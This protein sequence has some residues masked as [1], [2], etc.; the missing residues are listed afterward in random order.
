MKSNAVKEWF[1]RRYTDLRKQGVAFP[2]AT[3]QL[4][5]SAIFIAEQEA[6]ER[7]EKQMQEMREEAIETHYNLCPK[8][9]V[10]TNG[11]RAGWVTCDFGGRC[12]K[13]CDYMND[14][15]NELNK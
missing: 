7:H 2:P 8:R 9:Y 13:D 4:L 14:F 12:K 15:I 6:E 3:R 10:R 1:N 5:E 11:I